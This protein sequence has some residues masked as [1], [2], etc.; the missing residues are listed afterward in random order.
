[1]WTL[2]AWGRRLQAALCLLDIPLETFLLFA[3]HPTAGSL[4]SVAALLIDGAILAYIGRPAVRALYADDAFDVD[5]T[6]AAEIEEERF[7][8]S[9]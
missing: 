3:N 9:L 5:D 2:Q 1:M 8:P 4:L 6:G 7:T